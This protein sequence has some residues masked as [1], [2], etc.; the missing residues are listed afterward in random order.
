MRIF[1]QPANDRLELAGES[2]ATF[3][4]DA[5]FQTPLKIL[6]ASSNVGKAREFQSLAV[7]HAIDID[8]LPDFAL[9]PSFEET[10]PT[11]AENA[12]GKALHYS[13][14]TT[15]PVLADDSGLVVPA[16]GGAPGVQSARYA[17]PNATDADRCR[18]LLDAMHGKSGN[19][20]RARFVCVLALAHNA[21][22][23]AI[24]SNFVDGIITDSPRGSD[25]FGYDPVFYFERLDKT[26]A[27]MTSEEKNQ[28]SHRARA[29]QGVIAFLEG[30]G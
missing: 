16:L 15:D 20:R 12:A 5:C 23:I 4:C 28:Y 30:K 19:E 29:F 13:R 11:F 9:L 10:A 6:I 18:K 2:F 22:A 1:P 24:V 7:G 17:G 21:R 14:F 3:K 25:G 8:P 26:F 27:Q